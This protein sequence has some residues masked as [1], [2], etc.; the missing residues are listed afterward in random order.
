MEYCNKERETL[1][2][3]KKIKIASYNSAMKKYSNTSMQKKLNNLILLI[4]LNLTNTYSM[5]D[6]KI[7]L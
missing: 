4:L 6:N 3:S 1:F 2:Y 7:L 5:M